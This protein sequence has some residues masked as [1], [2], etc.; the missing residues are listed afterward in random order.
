LLIQVSIVS[1]CEEDSDDLLD[2]ITIGIQ[3][4]RVSI[5]KMEVVCLR[6]TVALSSFRF[7]IKWS[8]S[9]TEGG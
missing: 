1:V 4:A 3:Y 6:C 7:L 2:S 9:F 5:I 8:T